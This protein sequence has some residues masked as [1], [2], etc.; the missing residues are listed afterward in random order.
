MKDRGKGSLEQTSES[1]KLL[2]AGSPYRDPTP[3]PT[4]Q[5]TDTNNA[6]SYSPMIGPWQQRHPQGKWK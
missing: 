3:K 5:Q 4:I 2:G 6:V 1:L